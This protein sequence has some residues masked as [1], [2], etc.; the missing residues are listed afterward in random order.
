MYLIAVMRKLAV[1]D[2]KRY[3]TAK[4]YFSLIVAIVI[5]QFIVVLDL[6]V[7]D[8]YIGIVMMKEILLMLVA[9]MNVTPISF[10]YLLV[11]LQDSNDNMI[12]PWNSE[13]GTDI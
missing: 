4:I 13:Y 10:K 9:T 3:A 11:E 5:P 7:F 8:L 2:L 1:K 12:T 6:S